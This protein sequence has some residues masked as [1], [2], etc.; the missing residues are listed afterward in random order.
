MMTTKTRSVQLMSLMLA[1]MVHTT[2]ATEAT[3]PLSV[4]TLVTLK[5]GRVGD[6]TALIPGR[7]LKYKVKFNDG[8]T[9][10]VLAS[11]VKPY[12]EKQDCSHDRGTFGLRKYTSEAEKQAMYRNSRSGCKRRPHITEC[13]VLRK[14]GGINPALLDEESIE[15]RNRMGL[16]QLRN[17][18]HKSIK[19]CKEDACSARR[20]EPRNVSA[21]GNKPSLRAVEKAHCQKLEQARK[22][23]KNLNQ[24]SFIDTAAMRRSFTPQPRS[25]NLHEAK[26]SPAP[27]HSGA[28]LF[29]QAFFGNATNRR[30]LSFRERRLLAR[31]GKIKRGSEHRRLSFRGRRLLAR[32]RRLRRLMSCM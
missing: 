25:Y 17:Y 5:D 24:P 22:A 6:I 4:D 9:Q 14:D 31:K 19:E 13:N 30:R 29:A 21:H 20:S 11:K 10:N 8:K 15:L 2:L 18:H 12:Y 32:E 16:A 1:A 27:A 7:E 28:H 26:I 23:R 3:K